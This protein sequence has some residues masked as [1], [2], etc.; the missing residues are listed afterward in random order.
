MPVKQQGEQVPQK[1]PVGKRDG[2]R[3]RHAV[4]LILDAPGREG[5]GLFRGDAIGVKR[6]QVLFEEIE[7]RASNDALSRPGFHKGLIWCG[8][9]LVGLLSD[10]PTKINDSRKTDPSRPY[11]DAPRR[12][13]RGGTGGARPPMARQ[14]AWK[15]EDQGQKA[16]DDE[17]ERHH[18]E[19]DLPGDDLERKLRAQEN[20]D[21]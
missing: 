2:R 18:E 8:L 1:D 5:L 17:H 19:P 15:H 7:D 21:N 16:R 20:A 11:G 3:Q 9:T 10:M 4:D 14:P 12:R 13:E 6:M